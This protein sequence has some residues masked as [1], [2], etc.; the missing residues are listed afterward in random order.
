M[1]AATAA[2]NTKTCFFGIKPHQGLILNSS[3]SYCYNRKERILDVIGDS[4]AKNNV[5]ISN[6]NQSHYLG[7]ATFV[8]FNKLGSFYSVLIFHI[9]IIT[10]TL[11]YS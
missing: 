2:A 3:L 6:L 10:I 5:N 1:G 11:C 9:I 4:D 8:R 7:D